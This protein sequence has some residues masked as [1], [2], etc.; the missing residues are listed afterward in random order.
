V[1]AQLRRNPAKVFGEAVVQKF[2][3]RAMLDSMAGGKVSEII[4]IFPIVPWPNGPLAKS[5][6][7]IRANVGK[8][9]LDAGAAKSAFEGANHRN[10]RV[11]WK[12]CVAI[13]AV[14]SEFQHRRVRKSPGLQTSRPR[15]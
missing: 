10:L 8:N 5:T 1:L 6:P 9:H 14:W 12:R 15:H 13:F 2:V 7:A 4:S 11:W 3:N